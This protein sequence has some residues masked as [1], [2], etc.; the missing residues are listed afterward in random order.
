MTQ[1]IGG[2]TIVPQPKFAFPRSYIWGLSIQWT[3]FYLA[4]SIPLI[5]ARRP[6]DNY[7]YFTLEI[8]ERFYDWNSNR[9]T[10]DYFLTDA[11]YTSPPSPTH[12]PLPVNIEITHWPFFNYR[13]T[14]NISPFGLGVDFHAL[15]LPPA[16]STYWTPP[17]P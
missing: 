17:W 3:D 10:L 16:P 13:P 4:G 7:H 9:W 2:Q 11:W 14:I 8:D 15:Q 6:S 5:E 1:P 12:I